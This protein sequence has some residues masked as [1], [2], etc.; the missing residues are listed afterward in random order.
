MSF[1]STL[2]MMCAVALAA[3]MSGCITVPQPAPRASPERDA[4]AKTFQAP[5]EGKANLYVF[6]DEWRGGDIAAI[7]YLD[8]NLLGMTT[9]KTYL[10]AQVGPGIHKI[11]SKLDDSSEVE[12]KAEAGRTYFV[13]QEIK[14][15]FS[16]GTVLH[17]VDEQRGRPGV[18]SCELVG[19]P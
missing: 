8:G 16:H 10:H 15:S 7:V 4:A 2:P 6:R 5:T 1:R 13:W 9:H 14:G 18:S 3:A 19:Q 11:V 17:V 12:V